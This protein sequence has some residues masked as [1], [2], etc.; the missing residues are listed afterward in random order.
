MYE[1]TKFL[2]TIKN[3]QSQQSEYN[4]RFYVN[5]SGLNM[6]YQKGQIMEMCFWGCLANWH[7]HPNDYVNLFPDH[8]SIIDFKYIYNMTCKS[9]LVGSHLI[10]TPKYIYVVKYKCNKVF[11]NT[12]AKIDD[13]WEDVKNIDRSSHHFRD[14]YINKMR[15]VGFDIKIYN[16]YDRV[17]IEDIHVNGMWSSAFKYMFILFIIIIFFFSV[18]NKWKI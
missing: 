6:T 11:N 8:P 14:Q 2:K 18:E 7:T 10:F 16:W 13:I 4:G 3:L 17:Y 1:I 15:E 9:R 5:K 12:T